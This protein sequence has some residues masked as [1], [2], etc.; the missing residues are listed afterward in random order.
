MDNFEL[1]ISSVWSFPERG[2]WATHNPKYRGNFAPQIARNVI[3]RYSKE[4]DLVLDPMVGGG[5]SLIEAK[6]LNRKSIGRDQLQCRRTSR[7]D[8]L[9]HKRVGTPKIRCYR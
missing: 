9:R 7:R 4:G 5:T 1:E 3:I 2:N 6:L 8:P